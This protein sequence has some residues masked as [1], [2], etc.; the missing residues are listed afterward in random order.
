MRQG[1]A[2]NWVLSRVF[3]FAILLPPVARETVVR[4]PSYPIRSEQVLVLHLRH[5]DTALDAPVTRR[6][7]VKA[8][9]AD[10]TCVF[11]HFITDQALVRA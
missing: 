3:L 7:S 6:C 4:T 11:F 8:Y 9:W 5:L 10:H 2:A 1:R